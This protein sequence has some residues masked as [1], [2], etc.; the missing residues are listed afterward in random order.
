MWEQVTVGMSGAHV[1]RGAG[2]YRKYAPDSA[3]EAAKLTWLAEHGIPAPEV[4]DAGDGWFE[5]REVPG[6]SAAEPWPERRHAAVVDALADLARALHALPVEQCPFNRRLAVTVP[7]ARAAAQEG[8][9]ELDEL[10]ECRA[11]WNERRLLAELD[12]TMPGEEDLV[13]THGDLCL[14]NIMLDPESVRVTGVLDVGTLGVADR[15][16]DL[17]IATRSL[18]DDELNP[19]YTHQASGRFLKRYGVAPEHTKI[20]FYRLLD[21]FC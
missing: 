1:W 10:D 13:V 17:A 5:T 16:V 2:V 8:R 9:I 15:Y 11:G 19:Q 21:E 7:L 12:R 3:C 14:P 20:E 18:L 6:R 4:L